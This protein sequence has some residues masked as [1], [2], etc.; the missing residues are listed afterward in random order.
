MTQSNFKTIGFIGLG[1]MGSR[2]VPH[3]KGEAAL[4][5]CDVDAVRTAELAND[6]GG[7]AVSVADMADAD[8]VVLMLPN[9]QIVDQLLNGS[10]G[11]KGLFDVLRP[12]AMV[13]DMSSSAPT[14]SI[15]NAG[16]AVG[17]GLKF[18]DAPVSGGIR[19]AEAGS[20]AIMVG[21]ADADYQRALPTLKKMGGN[22]FSVGK[23]GAGHAVKSLNNLMSAASL[24][25]SSEVFAVGAKF[26]LDPALMLKVVNASSGQ[27]W[28]TTA[29]WQPAV[30]ERGFNF[31]FTMQ[32]MEKDVRV[33]M[34]L[35]D[36]M[37]SDAQISRAIAAT[38]AK[39][40]KDA[41]PGADM[42]VM[43]QQAEKAIGL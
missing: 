20:L 41:P 11:G 9:S 24:A 5:L 13:I 1:Q 14:N 42:T 18:I 10:S 39:A 34:S 4:L 23:I 2:M 32:L 12:G 35:F 19:G 31:G 27:N 37:G 6:L 3:L 26:G 17:R 29:L 22:V 36:A 33:A 28:V 15:A 16:I 38:W 40:L 8:A 21:G 43:A 7:K 30:V 25:V